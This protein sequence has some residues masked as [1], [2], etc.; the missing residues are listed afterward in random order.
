MKI[1]FSYSIFFLQ[2]SGGISR[3]FTNLSEILSNYNIKASIFAPFSKNIHLKNLKKNKLSFYI[4]RFP[5]WKIIALLNNF[6]FK[7]ISQKYNPDII[8]E[9]YYNKSNFINFK[10]KIKVLTVYDLIHEKFQ[11]VYYKKNIDN[12]KEIINYSDHLICISKNTQKDL[13]DYYKVKKGKT[14]VIYL[15]GDHLKN[16]YKKFKR[17]NLIKDKYILFVG[18]RDRYKNF[19]T[20]VSSIN[21]SKKLIKFKIVCFGG[22][23]FNNFEIKK[24][25][26]DDRFINIQGDDLVLRNLYLFADVYVNTSNYE[27]FGI[28]NLEAMSLRCPIVVSDINVF[29]EI[30]GNSCLYFKKNNHVDLFKQI[31][32]AISNQNLRNSLIIKGYN[33]SKNFTW[34]KCTRKT[35]SLYKKLKKIN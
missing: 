33:R 25:K 34:K 24:Y 19:K 31:D 16:K 10:N 6:I 13:I 28:T 32:K 29:R 4:K 17:E 9:T 26:I 35:L 22:G 15:G 5:N 3:Y 1:L 7:L 11:K 14:S 21:F 30:C 12:K 27:G 2:K 18:S 8:H 23:K 20:L